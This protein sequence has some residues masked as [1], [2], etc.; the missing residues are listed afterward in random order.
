[1]VAMKQT[2]EIQWAWNRL[3]KYSGHETDHG[4]L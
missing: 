3:W 4:K 1:M 2:M